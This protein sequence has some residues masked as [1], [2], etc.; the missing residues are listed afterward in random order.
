MCWSRNKKIIFLFRAL[1]LMPDTCLSFSV[2]R[3]KLSSLC[4]ICSL[5]HV[6]LSLDK[7]QMTIYLSLGKYKILLFPHPCVLSGIEL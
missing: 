6:K 7:Y 1:N 4:I 5:G 3:A 2:F